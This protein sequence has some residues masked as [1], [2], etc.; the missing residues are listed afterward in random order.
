MGNLWES[1]LRGK[2]RRPNMDCRPVSIVSTD[3]GKGVC[4]RLTGP[5]IVACQWNCFV[6]V[7]RQSPVG[8]AV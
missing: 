7:S 5:M 1:G 6:H 4:K 3:G 8:V 2:T